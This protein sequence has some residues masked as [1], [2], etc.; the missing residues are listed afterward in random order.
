MF[1]KRHYRALD[2]FFFFKLDF[3]KVDFQIR[4][5]SLISLEKEVECYLFCPKRAEANFVQVFNGLNMGWFY[6]SMTLGFV[7]GFWF[8][9]GPL[10]LNKQWRVLYFQFLDQLEYKLKGVVVQT[11]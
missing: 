11:C 1:L 4:D 9:L 7:V 2:F 5:I 10:L 6:V 3:E 8:V